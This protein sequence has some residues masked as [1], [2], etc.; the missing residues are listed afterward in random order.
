MVP[1]FYPLKQ[2]FVEAEENDALHFYMIP[3]F[4]HLS[5]LCRDSRAEVQNAGLSALQRVLLVPE[6]VILSSESW[7]I[8]IDKILFSLLSEYLKLPSEIPK[9]R[10]N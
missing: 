10:G 7:M 2:N 6:L 3:A 5:I 1:S 4:Q 8:L 9:E